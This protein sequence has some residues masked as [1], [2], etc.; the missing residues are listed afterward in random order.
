MIK[1]I[2]V[3]FLLCFHNPLSCNV[4][5]WSAFTGECK[6]SVL[7]LLSL[8]WV[9]QDKKYALILFLFTQQKASEDS[10]PGVAGSRTPTSSLHKFTCRLK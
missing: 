5:C 2:L 9:Y 1:P 3:S 6:L 10:G 8:D 7:G 4:V